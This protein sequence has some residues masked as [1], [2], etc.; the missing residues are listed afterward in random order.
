MYRVPS[1]VNVIKPKK[2][3]ATSLLSSNATKSVES[4]I[5]NVQ[6]V[7]NIYNK[8]VPIFEQSKPMIDNIKTTFK[9]AKAFRRF[10]NDSSLE[11]AF[12]NLPDFEE[13]II[14][15]N[16]PNKVTNPFYP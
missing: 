15:N 4:I 2:A 1:F 3:F 13:Q 11:K 6:K 12:D 10:S 16:K 7:L 8:A 14:E 5:N 9:V